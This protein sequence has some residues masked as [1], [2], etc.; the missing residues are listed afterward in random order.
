MNGITFGNL[1]SYRDLHL[2]LAE[3]TISAPSPKVET[4]DVPGGDGV[5][6]LT[7]FFG[8][9]KYNNRTLSFVFNTAVPKSQFLTLFSRVQNLLHGQKMAI[10]FDE[11]PEW[12]YIGR[13]N[14]AEW[15]ADKRVGT[16][17]VDCDCEP[18]KYR[19][20][21]QIVKLCGLNMINLDAGIITDE[22]VWT[23]DAT[24]YTFTRR[25]GTGGSF[26]HWII[27]V[28]KG[29]QYV[30]SAGGTSTTRLL[31]VYKDK[32][33]GDLVAKEGSEKPCIFTAE[34]NG[35][36]VFG[37]YVTSQATAGSFTNIMLHEGSAVQPFVAYDATAKE[38][39][40][41]F[42]NERKAVI[43]TMYTHGNVTAKSTSKTVTLS[44]GKQI[45]TDFTF[46]KGEN[47]LTFTGNGIVVV[48]W[49]EGGL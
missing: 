27:P 16:I 2:V 1:H 29:Q 11:E 30:F 3:K 42:Q 22:G 26:V 43:P 10:Y 48:E 21:S 23:K 13:I 37:I 49:K 39:A 18:F 32:L 34:Q 36:Y 24:G 19:L 45:A 33:Y 8:E 4:I 46:V 31:Y 17:T 12:Y 38:V 7:E 41:T 20:S 6:D 5:L 47:S 14:I 28:K 25:T 9:V 40:V 44:D 35:L 15:K